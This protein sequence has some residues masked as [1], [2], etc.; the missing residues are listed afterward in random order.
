MSPLAEHIREN[1]IQEDY[2]EIADLKAQIKQLEIDIQSW[3]TDYRKSIARI[4]EL[5]YVISKY[6]MREINKSYMLE[7]IKALEAALI[8]MKGKELL[9][10][11]DGGK[12]MI[13]G[14]EKCPKTC[15]R[16]DEECEF[17]WCPSKDF[18]SEIA[19]QQLRAEG[20]ISGQ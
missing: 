10:M 1:E 9:S 2:Q 19:R 5:E 11:E 18:W 20:L 15:Y 7:R 8:F 17:E 3:I 6:N 4:A 13:A 14:I 12:F 16:C